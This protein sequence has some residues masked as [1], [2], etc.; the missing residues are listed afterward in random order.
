MR[1]QMRRSLRR[2]GRPLRRPEI[3]V[4]FF[5]ISR[6]PGS[7]AGILDMDCPVVTKLNRIPGRFT[8]LLLYFFFGFR[9]ARL[10]ARG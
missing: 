8:D 9:R 1:N 10:S 5:S 3:Q 6:K 7:Y 4:S 2:K